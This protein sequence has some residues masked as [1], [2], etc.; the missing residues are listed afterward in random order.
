MQLSPKDTKVKY[1][2]FAPPERAKACWVGGS[3]ISKLG[4]FKSLWVTKNEYKEHG[5]RIFDM[6]QF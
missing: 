3:S 6:K 1:R 2:F 5:D 4:S